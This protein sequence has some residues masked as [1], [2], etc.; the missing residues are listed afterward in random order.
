MDEG[1]RHVTIAHSKTNCNQME[2]SICHTGPNNT[3]GSPALHPAAPGA[4]EMGLAL[5]NNKVFEMK[6]NVI[7]KQDRLAGSSRE[8][9]HY[10]CS[11][12][13][14]GVCSGVDGNCYHCNCLASQGTTP[15]SDLP[16]DHVHTVNKQAWTKRSALPA[17]FEPATSR[18]PV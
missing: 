17:G 5:K 7:D 9:P 6:R 3:L 1:N 16:W 12:S 4:S 11:A 14:S 15:P 8:A 18:L 10:P 13:S 2:G